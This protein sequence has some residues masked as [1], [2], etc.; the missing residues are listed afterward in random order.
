MS[1]AVHLQRATPDAAPLLRNLLELYVH[2][3]SAIFP[4]EIGP[5]G[6]FGYERLALYWSEPATR[7]AFVIRRG[8]RVAGFALATRGSPATDDPADLDVAEF[9]V[10]R[11]HRRAGVG[12][13]AAFALW[14]GMPGRWIVRVSEANRAGLAFWREVVRAYTSGRF[15]ESARP[16]LPGWRI[17]SFTTRAAAARS[18]GDA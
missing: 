11:A 16:A 7:H 12:R 3:L 13:D 4:V 9:F 2:D 14:D 15:G 8:E 10:L 6:R 18:G 5:D 1:E 17:L